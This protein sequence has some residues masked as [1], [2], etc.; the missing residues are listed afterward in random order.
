MV[1]T[2]TPIKMK[3]VLILI[4]LSHLQTHKPIVAN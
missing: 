1:T 4:S 3:L 2:E